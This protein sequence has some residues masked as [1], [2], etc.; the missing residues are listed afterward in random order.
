MEKKFTVTRVNEDSFILAV[1]ESHSKRWFD[2]T[3]NVWIT[4]GERVYTSTCTLPVGRKVRICTEPWLKIAPM[5]DMF[6]DELEEF[7]MIHD[8]FRGV[9][10]RRAYNCLARYGVRTVVQLFTMGEGE[11]ST[12]RNLGKKTFEALEDFGREVGLHFGMTEGEIIEA[13]SRL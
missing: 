9:L 1:E 2:E 4:T 13:L 6:I 11:V 12:I 5:G 10:P 8:R 7:L 3:S